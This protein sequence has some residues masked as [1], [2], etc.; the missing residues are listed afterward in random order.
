[1]D[2]GTSAATGARAGRVTSWRPRLPSAA[3][4]PT[5]RSAGH[6]ASAAAPTACAAPAMPRFLTWRREVV[7]VE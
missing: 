5:A 6:A 2:A 3:S 4:K 7:V 1:V